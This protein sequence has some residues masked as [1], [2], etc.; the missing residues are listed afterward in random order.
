M[1]AD[2]LGNY[3][4]LNYYFYYNNNYYYYNTF[5]SIFFLNLSLI[6]VKIN[7]NIPVRR[8]GLKRIACTEMAINKIHDRFWMIEKYINK[9]IFC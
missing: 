4:F 3:C 1:T 7:Y 2:V 8:R 5:M 9:T 6:E